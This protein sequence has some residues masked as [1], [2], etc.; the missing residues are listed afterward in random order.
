[1]TPDSEPITR[2]SNRRRGLLHNEKL[3]KFFYQDDGIKEYEMDGECSMHARER[4][5][6]GT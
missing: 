5:G 2:S 6:C 3:H 1:M 4:N